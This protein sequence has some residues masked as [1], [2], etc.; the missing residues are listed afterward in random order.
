MPLAAGTVWSVL[1]RHHPTNRCADVL[2]TRIVMAR[3]RITARG[4]KHRAV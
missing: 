1:M 2:V 3:E 4:E